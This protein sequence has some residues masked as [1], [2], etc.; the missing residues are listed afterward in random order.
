MTD[1][2]APA[3]PGG[4]R[5]RLGRT[6]GRTL[7]KTLDRTFGKTLNQ[8]LH[9]TLG[10]ALHQT[11]GR[12]PGRR[13]G[14]V[15]H[16]D[17][18]RVAGWAVDPARPGGPA[19][20]SLHVDG[21]AVLNILADLPRDDVSSQGLAPLNCGFD[22]ALPA[23][24]RDG[25]AHRVE[26]RLGEAGPVLRGGRL[27]IP[28]RAGAA[29]ARIESGLVEG[30]AWFD[31]PRGAV[32]GWA[33]GT[34]ALTGR[35]DDGAEFAVALDREVA[36]FG[37]GVQQGF[38]VPVPPAL[39]DGQVH[40]LWLSSGGTGIDGSPVAVRRSG[41]R[42]VVS[43]VSA[44]GGRVTLRLT[45]ETGAPV[46]RPVT[47]RA[48]G[49]PLEVR[50]ETGTGGTGGATGRIAI[51]LPGDATELVLTSAGPEGQG[52]G[53]GEGGALLARYLVRADHRS[54]PA[55]LTLDEISRHLPDPDL[56]PDETR[57]APGTGSV[58][59]PEDTD[60]GSQDTDAGTGAPP[61]PPPTWERDLPDSVWAASL[62]R[63]TASRAERGE[64][65]EDERL[66][67]AE[68]A[69]VPLARRPLV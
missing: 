63:L 2:P 45:D 38:L 28:G 51:D 32:T 9:Q 54:A 66:M 48:D 40:R 61:L 19:R 13:A 31:R 18:S 1:R 12:L 21:V 53:Q 52:Q 7:A 14:Y 49:R 36:G 17:D 24:L 39:C 3:L 67:R 4:P 11:L 30:L 27:S 59:G 34:T 58:Q 62:A 23:R 5:P 44:S 47:A 35:W 64:I 46:A 15:D 29:P 65:A 6:L 42:P 25:R 20:L 37:K 33:A 41:D 43:L 57:P 22:A 56:D 26:L 60:T 68:V 8:T 55:A 69:A 10:R 16:F 50:A